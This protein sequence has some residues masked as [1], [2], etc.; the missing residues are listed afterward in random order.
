MI[1]NSKRSL[2]LLKKKDPTQSTESPQSCIALLSADSQITLF[3][4]ILKICESAV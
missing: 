2:L 1:I 3:I 4:N